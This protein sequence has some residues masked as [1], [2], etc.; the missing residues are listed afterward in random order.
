M[1]DLLVRVLVYARNHAT[2]SMRPWAMHSLT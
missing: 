1:V 2:A